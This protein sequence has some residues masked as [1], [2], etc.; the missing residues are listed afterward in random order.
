MRNQQAIAHQLMQLVVTAAANAISGTGR[1]LAQL[2][3]GIGSLFLE[4]KIKTSPSRP[5]KVKISKTRYPVDYNASL[6]K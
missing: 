2:R 4:A 3:S 1:R 5:R 6:L